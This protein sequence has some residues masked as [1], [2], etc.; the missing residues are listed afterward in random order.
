MSKIYCS[1]RQAD[2]Y[3]IIKFMQIITSENKISVD[4]LKEMAEKMFG[5][6]I[7]AVVDVERGIMVVD[8]ELHSDEEVLLIERGSKRTDVWGINFYLEFKPEDERFVEFDSMINIK[9]AQGNRSRG[10]DDE[11][12]RSKIL[13]VVKK[14][15]AEN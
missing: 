7:K 10:I 13:A 3:D 9:P 2:F 5:N 1:N 12:T 11:Q 8:G 4:A 14:L 6:L 15:I